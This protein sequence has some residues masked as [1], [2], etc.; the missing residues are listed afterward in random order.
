MNKKTVFICVFLISLFSAGADSAGRVLRFTYRSGDSVRI[1]STVSESVKVNGRPNHRAEVIN[2]VSA[3]ITEVDSEGR[4]FHEATF[5]TTE[6]STGSAASSTLTYGEEYKSSYWRDVR[7]NYEIGGE[8]F[9]PVVRD[10]PIFPEAAVKPGDS[11]TAEGHE[12]HDLRRTFGVAEPFIVPF[13]AQYTYLRDEEGISSDSAHTK[14]TFQVIRAQYSLFYESPLP[15]AVYITDDVPTT[16]MGY[17]DQTIW[18]DNEKGQIDHYTEQFRIVLE[19]Y[20]GNTFDFQGNARAE[21]TDFERSATDENVQTV[22]EKVRE[23]DLQDVSVTKTERGLTISIE[24]IQFSPDS[25]EL[26]ESEKT[27]IQKIAEILGEYPNDLLISGHTARVG[28]EESCQKLS[29]ERAES[30]ANYLIQSGVRDK[31]HI[32]TQGFG[33]RVP[34]A[35]NA[36]EEGKAKNRRVEITILDN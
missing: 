29:E 5:M 35:P 16:T 25:A 26:F 7:G 1:L 11:W 6:N 2:R 24:N 31:Y 36:T 22:L 19:T 28:T 10:V 21:V 33:A 23:M 14:K 17:S 4:G 27:K 8:F 12:A 13:T 15:D 9:M 3:E 30:V 32:F 20:F 34:V 18:W